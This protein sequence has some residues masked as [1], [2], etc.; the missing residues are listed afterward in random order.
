MKYHIE[1]VSD[2]G[3]PLIDIAE[4]KEWLKV[5]H[6]LEDATILNLIER[7]INDF[8]GF[9]YSSLQASTY[10]VLTDS[11]NSGCIPLVRGPVS[12]ISSVYYY[13]DTN[14]LTELTSAYYFLAAGTPDLL[15]RAYDYTWPSIYRRPDAVQVTYTTNPTV[16]SKVKERVLHGVAYLYENRS[17]LDMPIDKVYQSLVM[18][19]RRKHF[20]I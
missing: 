16:E 5:T 20:I 17:S 11:W 10:K 18:G 8:E 3:V 19:T 7:V 4:A 15:M 6:S 14:V 1:R 9:S 2:S 12:A 13:S